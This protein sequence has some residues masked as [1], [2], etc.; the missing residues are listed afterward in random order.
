MNDV[1]HERLVAVVSCEA[2]SGRYF[3]QLVKEA[4][5]TLQLDMSNCI[6]NSTD[7]A[8]NMQGQYNG[9]SALLSSH[10]PNQVHVWC[11]AHILNLVMGDTTGV[12]IESASLFS[13][14]NDL[15][16]FIRESYQRMNVWEKKSQDPHHRRLSSIGE[17]RWGA[18]D[19][20][21]KKV[22]GFFGNPQNALFV[23]VVLTLTN[24][25]EMASQKPNVRVKGRGFKEALPKYETILTAQTFL[26]I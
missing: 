1:V 7:G 21:L 12:V 13:L 18:K 16:V 26:C 8:A 17:T 19:A 10:S 9:F 11:Y 15:A 22:F 6:G 20:A 5:D 25:E 24:I 23:Y 4:I 14:L 2:S 3:S